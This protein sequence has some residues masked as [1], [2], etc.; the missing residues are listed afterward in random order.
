MRPVSSL[1][2]EHFEMRID[3]KARSTQLTLRF[4]IN[5]CEIC[6][7]LMMF[8]WFRAT[9]LGIFSTPFWLGSQTI[10]KMIVLTSHRTS[11]KY[12]RV[13]C[14][15]KNHPKTNQGY[16]HA[17]T[18]SHCCWSLNINLY[19]QSSSAL[20]LHH[21]R[22]HPCYTNHH[23]ASLANNKQWNLGVAFIYDKCTG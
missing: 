12:P 11:E 15:P 16:P 14:I 17:W 3:P 20:R 23:S 5:L 6:G 2:D 7:Y 1:C 4:S 21:L 9:P 13:R 10:S 19:N 8:W 22:M 18:N